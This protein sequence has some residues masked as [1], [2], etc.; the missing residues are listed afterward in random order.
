M[1]L[2]FQLACSVAFPIFTSGLLVVAIFVG[3]GALRASKDD[4]SAK[5]SLRGKVRDVALQIVASRYA[6]T[7][8][9]FVRKEKY[10]ADLA[11]A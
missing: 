5:T 4:L 10:A 8:Y 1:R 9:A 2:G 11:Q 7:N 3:L 6:T